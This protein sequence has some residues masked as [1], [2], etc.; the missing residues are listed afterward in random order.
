VNS[1]SMLMISDVLNWARDAIRWGNL[2]ERVEM[3]ERVEPIDVGEIADFY[4]GFFLGL[5]IDRN[6]K[7]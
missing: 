7:G 1:D 6:Y 5:M 4:E 2:L 3:G